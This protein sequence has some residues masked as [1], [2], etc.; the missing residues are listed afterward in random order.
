VLEI[1][2]LKGYKQTLRSAIEMPV[3]MGDEL[4]FF[5]LI[6]GFHQ[7]LLDICAGINS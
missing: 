5:L 1:L 7:A 3:D 6:T 2:N 4:N